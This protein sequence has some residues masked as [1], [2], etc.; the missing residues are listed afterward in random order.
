MRSLEVQR[1]GTSPFLF[2][3]TAALLAACTSPDGEPSRGGPAA[4]VGAHRA[5][6]VASPSA[7]GALRRLPPGPSLAPR[8]HEV[9]VKLRN[10]EHADALHRR[11]QAPL[12]GPLDVP[13][14]AGL[15]RELARFGVHHARRL[16]EGAAEPSLQRTF[17]LHAT[18]DAAALIAALR[19]LPEVEYAE[20]NVVAR[21]V[22]TPNDP[23][24]SSSGAWG[25]AFR[26]LWGLQTIEAAA[27][28]D[29][30]QGAGVVVAVIDTGVDYDHPDL[31][32]NIWQNPGET[33]TDAQGRDKRTN[34]VD[35][36]GNGQVDD[37]HGYN[38]VTSG[39]ANAS[40]DPNDDFGHG[41]H[42]AGIIAAVANDAIGVVGVAPQAKIMPVKGLDAGGSGSLADLANGIYYAARNGARVINASWGGLA[43]APV[44]T[45][46]DAVAYAHDTKGVVFVAAA[47]NDGRDVGT[48]AVGFFPASARNAVAVSAFTHDDARANFSNFGPKLDVAAP[49]GGDGDPSGAL[50]D[51]QRSI[52]SLLAAGANAQ[53]TEDGQLVVGGRYLRQ[54]GTS[55]AAPHVAGVAALLLAK[56]P[57]W[58]PEQVRQALRAGSADTGAVGFDLD[59]GYG[60]LDALH[61]LGQAAPLSVHLSSLNA[62]LTGLAQ[63]V[64]VGTASGPGLASWQLSWGA[65]ALPDSWVTIQTSSAAVTSAPLATWSLAGVPEGQVSLRLNAVTSDGRGYEDRLVVKVDNVV[66]T[67]PDPTR[68]SSFR[69]GPITVT[70]T[71]APTDLASYHVDVYSATTGWLATAAVTLPNGGTQA[72]RAG[73]LASWDPTGL[74]ADHY[75]LYVRATL[76]SGLVVEKKA[77]VILDPTLHPGWPVPFSLLSQGA[78]GVSLLEHMTAADLDGDGAAELVFAY[79]TQVTALRSDGTALAGWP[80]PINGKNALANI[81]HGPAVGDI[82]GDGKP[83]VVAANCEPVDNSCSG[84]IFAWRADGTTL[85]GWPVPL[86]GNGHV[87]LGDI[88]GDGVLDV[89]AS[90][91]SGVTVRK[92][93]G[94]TLPGFPVGLEEVDPPAIGDL[95]GDGK[96]EIVVAGVRNGSNLWVVGNQGVVR[97]GFP[98]L[99]SGV[100]IEAHSLP[101][102]AD[103]DGDGTLEIAIGGTDGL[104]HAVRADG[105]ELPGFPR[106]TQNTWLN[107]PTLGD[108]DG[109]GRPEIVVGNNLV[110]DGV[111]DYIDYSYAFRANG[112]PLPG[113]PVSLAYSYLDADAFFGAGAAALAD[114]DGDGRADAIFSSDAVA[115]APRAL[116]A[117]RFDG[118]EA[119]GWPKPTPYIGLDATNTVAVADVDGDGLLEAAY[120]DQ[121]GEIRLY[122]LPTSKT[123]PAPWPMFQHDPAHGGAVAAVVA[124]AVALSRAGWAASAS[125]SNGAPANAVDGNLKTRWSTGAP[126]TGGQWFQVDMKTTQRFSKLTLDA[127]TSGGD[128]PRGYQV[129][130]STD[131]SRWGGAIATGVGASPLV[132]ITFPPQ[133]A[134]YLRVVQTGKASSWWSIHELVVFGQP[135]SVV[136]PVA[137]AYVRDGGSAGTNF[138]TTSPLTVKNGTTGYARVGYLKFNLPAVPSVGSAKLR[139]YGSHA[140]SGAASDSAFAVQSTSWTEAGLTWNNKPPLGAKQGG[141]VPVNLTSQ[142]YEWDVTAWVRAQKAAGATSLSLAVA[143]DAPVNDPDNFNSREAASNKPELMIVH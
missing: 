52:L 41:T 118:A 130:V 81:Q 60:R 119:A 84:E 24:L 126:Q 129:F 20:P 6:L 142:Y 93:N 63:V 106:P 121:Q 64:V 133:T 113:W 45:I 116:H 31:A 62:T 67:A 58:T 73:T 7:A 3:V 12:A 109:D 89:V 108:L 42:V 19:A 135:S 100:A 85:P 17:H 39:T 95:D 90:N 1:Q 18:G 47:G 76:G 111:S 61:A 125:S 27:A 114:V 99:L 101:A 120:I 29:V 9:L 54:A 66:I 80:R 140:V 68:V 82:D 48:E 77:S 43:D 87:A 35:D 107:S 46:L 97:P 136:T 36:D 102:L 94:V 75:D 122:D 55:M 25:Q 56:N 65:G 49:G 79:G 16:F 34:G 74:P 78:A 123:A 51:P 88:D 104:L 59:A 137:D 83:D 11:S 15:S 143:M 72:V 127:A 128:Y 38:F 117:L 30:T 98:R 40:N 44:Q 23:Y 70:G 33:G 69:A 2:A 138:G 91:W 32:A 105:S 139:L 10:K 22:S 53:M 37:F 110:F 21:V 14:S 115:S 50:F 92:G 26:D 86:D 132:T 103:L 141:S 5:A 57:S 131:G 134:R 13:G 28:W 124:P 96:N 4:E 8:P 71:V 112:A